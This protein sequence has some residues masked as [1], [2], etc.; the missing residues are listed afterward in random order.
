MYKDTWKCD[1]G[2]RITFFLILYVIMIFV[3]VTNHAEGSMSDLLIGCFFGDLI[4]CIIFFGFIAILDGKENKKHLER[5]RKMRIHYMDTVKTP[6]TL[7]RLFVPGTRVFLT[8]AREAQECKDY[9]GAMACY[10]LVLEKYPRNW[11]A[12]FYSAYCEAMEVGFQKGPKIISNCIN[13]VLESIKELEDSSEQNEAIKQIHADLNNYFWS[14]FWSDFYDRND[15]NIMNDDKL[16]SLMNRAEVSGKFKSLYFENIIPNIVAMLQLFGDKLVSE[17]G[18]NELTNS[19]KIKC[20]ED[21]L[22]ATSYQPYADILKEINPSSFAL[23]VYENRSFWE[24]QD[25]TTKG[26]LG[27]L[28]V[29]IVIFI[30][31]IIIDL[32]TK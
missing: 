32:L 21:L 2:L 31:C 7:K 10:R 15:D 17:I 20:Y 19:I 26:C 11:E 14:L 16:G 25:G 5:E 24:K 27:C 28:G 1:W 13:P 6:S 8:K 22:E 12:L 9:I 30:I 29:F 3:A 4:F 23:S 18:K